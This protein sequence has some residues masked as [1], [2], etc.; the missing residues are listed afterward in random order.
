[1]ERYTY[2]S[3]ITR[4]Q[5][6]EIRPILE[7]V[8]KKTK[9]RK[10]DLYDIFCAVLYILKSGCQWRM[11]PSDFPKWQDVYYYYY[12]AWSYKQSPNHP[13][14]LEEILKKVC[15]ARERDGRKPKTTMGIIDS[16]S[17]KN[18][19]SAREK[20]YDGGK[21]IS[22][23][24]QHLV[25]D[26][27]GFPHAMGV[28]TANVTDRDGA[29]QLFEINKERLSEVKRILADG[30]YDGEPFRQKTNQLLEAEVEIAKRNELHTFVVIPKRWVVER[31]FSWMDKC[32]RLWRNCEATINSS[33]HMMALCFIRILLKRT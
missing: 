8:R 32:R 11:L 24:K 7:V 22:G 16:R 17:V 14:V 9:P 6:E 29:L 20:G 3:D 19:E 5:F 30:G 27:N 28:T 18:T 25:T 21:K 31:S 2:P 23:I 15:E 1:M 13:S 10:V 33:F 12:Y 4:E 26:T